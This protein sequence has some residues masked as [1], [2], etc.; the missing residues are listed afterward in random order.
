[1]FKKIRVVCTIGPASGSPEMIRGLARSGMNVARLNFSHGTYEE[2]D[3]YLKAIRKVA[4]EL[5][6]PLAI[7]QDLP[8]P[9]I[10]TGALKHSTVNLEEGSE[11]VLVSDNILGDEHKVAT[12]FPYLFRDVKHG[13]TI[14]LNDGAI[15]LEATD[16]SGDEIKCKVVVGGTLTPE[17]GINVPGVSFSSV[18]LV[19]DKDL[20]YLSF[21][22]EKGV[23]FVALSFVREA[24]DICKVREFLKQRGAHIPIIA[25]IEKHEAVNNID[26]IISE[27]DGVMVARGD[28]GVEISQPK[29]PLLQKEIIE[30]CN[31][32]GKP[33]I[34]ATQML[35]SMIN[36]PFPTRAEVSDVANAILDGA[37]AVMLSAET[38]IGRYPVKTTLMMSQIALEV[39]MALPYSQ[40]LLQRG[41]NLAPEVDDAISY[42]ACHTAEQLGASCIVA[43]TS[44][45]STAARVSK[46]R[47]QAPILAITSSDAVSRRLVLNWGVNPYTVAKFV[48]V[49][50]MFEEAEKTALTSGM[51]KKGDLI[52]ITA[53]IPLGIPGSTNL[54]KV[55]QVGEEGKNSVS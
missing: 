2:H 28:L 53:G 26:A 48:G 4:A 31:R 21:G 37:D 54:I 44:S 40:I 32:A 49:D 27:A 24:S 41:E 7:L 39:E 35:E 11:F 8:G 33:V 23:D 47:P 30:K 17:R 18:P 10:R 55:Q 14:F 29:V 34:V 15:R 51:V 50:R 12:N 52:V 25:K 9:K 13:D 42:D 19:R 22:V 43:Y 1:M 16:V 3:A 36:S 46:Y 5:K 38:A 45:G 20:E 6:T